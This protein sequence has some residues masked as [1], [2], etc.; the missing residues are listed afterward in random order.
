MKAAIRL[1]Q[2]FLAALVFA[3]VANACTTGTRAQRE[4]WALERQ[5]VLDGSKRVVGRFREISRIE[6][7][8][9]PVGSRHFQ[10]VP[11]QQDPIPYTTINGEIL[12]PKGKVLYQVS[13]VEWHD[14]GACRWG[15]HPQNGEYGL[16]Y[17]GKPQNGVRD[18]IHFVNR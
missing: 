18:I 15:R 10:F 13:F 8:R 6:S 1:F 12:N 5:Q 11:E 4:A 17:L 3:G 2:V 14:L 16:F 7:G 9:A